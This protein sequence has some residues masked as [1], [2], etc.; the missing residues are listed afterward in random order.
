MIAMKSRV[1]CTVSMLTMA[2]TISATPPDAGESSEAIDETTGARLEEVIVTSERRSQNLL[3]VPNAVSAMSESQLLNRGVQTLG[4]IQFTTPGFSPSDGFGY[5][6]IYIRGVGNNIYVGADPSV[7]TYVDGV[8]RI[9]GT[10]TND[11][12]NLE[13]IEVLKGAQGGLYGR[14]ATGGVVNIITRHPDDVSSQTAH[15]VYG[16]DST[17]EA[18]AYV[19]FPLND[20]VAW[21]LAVTRQSH[22]P[23]IDNRVQP[24]PYSAENFPNGSFLGSPQE[25]A[26]FFNSAVSAPDGLQDQDLWAVDSKL[27]VNIGDSF[28][29]TLA[30]DYSRKEDTSGAAVV[31]KSPEMLRATATYLFS[32]FGIEANLPPGFFPLPEQEFVTSYGLG[33]PKVNLSDFGGSATAVLNLPTADLTFIAAYRETNSHYFADAGY[34]VAPVLTQ[35][36]KNDKSYYYG[37]ARITSTGPGRLQY[38]GGVTYLDAR[39]DGKTTIAYLPPL[40][41]PPSNDVRSDVENWSVYAQVG[42]DLTEALNLSASGRY[43]RESN[44]A[45]FLTPPVDGDSL[46]EEEFLPSAT[47]SYK[48]ADDG[49]VYARF[50]R[51]WKAGGINLVDRPTLFPTD[52]GKK[53]APEEVDTYEIG[54]RKAL[55]DYSVQLTGAVFYNDYRNLQTVTTGNALNPA[56]VLAIVN[57][58]KARTYGAEAN[59]LWRT[60]PSLTLGANVGYLDS[61]YIDFANR[62]GSVLN[63][64]D[65]SGQQMLFAP[66]WQLSLSADLD[67]PI[68]SRFRFVGSALVSYLSGMPMYLSGVPGVPHAAQGGYTLANLRIGIRT[69]DDRFEFALFGRNITDKAYFTVGNIGPLGHVY[70]YG[71]PRVIGGELTVNF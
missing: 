3:V 64:F 17:F 61:K 28:S 39:L 53:F 8:P 14:N 30:A 10:L 20:R 36:V 2:T 66:E 13:R 52:Y 27:R 70:G 16:T 24:D 1:L 40:P 71:N 67:K 26:D 25:T 68:G 48:L 37:E 44:R 42:Y 62:D 23:Y 69:L 57:A 22:D 5:T 9:Y 58:G 12:V 19:N 50:A 55:F 45:L 21:N 35:D 63:T 65:H 6:Q 33:K 49:V 54:Y 15:I 4:D 56:I 41:L 34:S 7:A 43:I 29:L 31:N 47:L 59:L 11:F 32:L 46:E 60:T 38:L 18:S 51:G